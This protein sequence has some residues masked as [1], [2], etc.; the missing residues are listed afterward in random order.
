MPGEP[1]RE[2]D[3]F[4][5]RFLDG[6]RTQVLCAAEDVK[7]LEV[8]A[9]LTDPPEHCRHAL[10][11]DAELLGTPAHFHARAFQLEVGIDPHRHTRAHAHAGAGRGNAFHLALGFKVDHDSCRSGLRKF[12]ISLAGAGKTDEMR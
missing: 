4:L 7:A 5:L 3:G 8:E 2:L 6:A 9:E 10:G 12:R 1:E 11:I